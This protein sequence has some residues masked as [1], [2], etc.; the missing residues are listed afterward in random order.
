MIRCN[1]E[2]RRG[3]RPLAAAPPPGARPRGPWSAW[4]DEDLLVEYTREGTGEAFA[5]LV[6]R[7]QRPLYTHLHKY[8]RDSGQVEDAFQATFLAVHL[9]RGEFDPRRRFR[10]WVYCIATTRAIDMFRRNRRHRRFSP[11]AWQAGHDPAAERQT[12]DDLPD[13]RVQPPLTQLETTENGQRLR[14]VVDS[15][16]ARL[17]DVIVQ[18]M[19]RGVAY[20]EAADLLKIPLGTVKS[21][22][23]EAL[24]R[25][26]KA[27]LATA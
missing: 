13:A 18:V 12:L 15:L 21:R 20:Q 1:S 10:P 25:L 6:H 3:H 19:L 5:E 2:N 26:R 11:D 24:L 16:P 14:R 8:L 7:Y 17:R 4:Q 27:P 23:H 22:L 9:R